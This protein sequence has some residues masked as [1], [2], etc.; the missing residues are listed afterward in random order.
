[1]NNK[2]NTW[3]VGWFYRTLIICLL[4]IS[5]WYNFQQHEVV[6]DHFTF[7]VELLER[8]KEL[9][10]YEHGWNTLTKALGIPDDQAKTLL[11]NINQGQQ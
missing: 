2:S 4:G 3:N 10:K 9:S 5:I 1:M 7:S 6:E 11:N 8:N